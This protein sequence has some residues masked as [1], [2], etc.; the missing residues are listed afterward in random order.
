LQDGRGEERRGE[1][2]RGGE[3]GGESESYRDWPVGSE[4]QHPYSP[5]QT[6][7]HHASSSLPGSMATRKVSKTFLLSKEEKRRG[8]L[9]WGIISA[10]S[11]LLGNRF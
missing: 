3:R 6:D 1:E 11:F 2:G 5:K 4:Q 7:H 9:Q 10:F 8:I